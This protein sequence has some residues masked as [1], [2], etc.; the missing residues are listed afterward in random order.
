MDAGRGAFC[1]VT[2]HGV[3]LP[4]PPVKRTPKPDRVKNPRGVMRPF[5][6]LQ[7]RQPLKDRRRYQEWLKRQGR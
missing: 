1:A 7:D 2:K 4:L 3:P 5:K 6:T